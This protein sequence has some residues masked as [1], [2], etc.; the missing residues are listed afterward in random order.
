MSIIT[1]LIGALVVR[2]TEL[3]DSEK[4]QGL[5]EY[6]L[7]VALIAVVSI[8]VLK[9][10]GV[11]VFSALDTTQKNFTGSTPATPTP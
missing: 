5:V 11:D 8:L 6:A 3:R 1:T 9:A 10:L 7:V 2:A 4:A